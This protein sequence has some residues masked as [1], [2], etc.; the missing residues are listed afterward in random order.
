MSLR[1]K[2]ELII[3]LQDG[4]NISFETSATYVPTTVFVYRDGQFQAKDFVTET[5]GTG[6]DLAEA[7][8][9]DESWQVRYIAVIP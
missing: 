5:G 9:P 7:P 6:F 2:T 1:H 8:E 4:I 3:G